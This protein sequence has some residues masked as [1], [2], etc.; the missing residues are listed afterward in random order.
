M[1][2]GN[3]LSVLPDRTM[4]APASSGSGSLL[5]MARVLPCSCAMR[6]M[7]AP[8]CTQRLVPSTRRRSQDRANPL[9]A[10]I[11][12]SGINSP[13]RITPGLMNPPQPHRGI[14]FPDH[15]SDI[16]SSFSKEYRWVETSW[17][18]W[19]F[20]QVMHEHESFDP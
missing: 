6:E 14:S 1:T 9:A 2:R 8:G 12:C 16:S 20:P 18:E 10:H 19:C 11:G 3:I 13:K 15:M 5:M 4:S 17:I 7:E